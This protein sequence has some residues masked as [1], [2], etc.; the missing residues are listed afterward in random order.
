MAHLYD[1]SAIKSNSAYYDIKIRGNAQRDVVQSSLDASTTLYVGNLPTTVKEEQLHELFSC[2][3]PIE[4]IVLGVDR[5][6]L[7][8]CGFCFVEYISRKDAEDCLKYING[9]QIIENLKP[10]YVDWDVGYSEGRELKVRR[11][12]KRGYQNRGRDNVVFEFDDK[13]HQ[14]KIEV[15]EAERSNRGYRDQYRDRDQYSHNDQYGYYQQPY[16]GGYGQKREQSYGAPRQIGK[17]R[18]SRSY[19]EDDKRSRSRSRTPEEM[20]RKRTRTD[21][22]R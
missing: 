16:R 12:G 3:G 2:A 20:P 6:T 21:E 8:P 1:E 9:M 5:E 14:L 22:D 13:K 7:E 19:D 18:R 4:R 11:G 17:R 10:I 15:K